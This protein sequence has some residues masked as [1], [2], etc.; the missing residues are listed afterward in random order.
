MNKYRR[1][2]VDYDY[3]ATLDDESLKYLDKFTNEYYHNDF[4]DAETDLHGQFN[5]IYKDPEEYTETYSKRKYVKKNNPNEKIDSY[6][7][8]K[9]ELYRENIA[10]QN[11]VLNLSNISNK[12][13]VIDN[14]LDTKVYD[15][16]FSKSELY[17]LAK[18]KG[19]VENYAQFLKA[20]KDNKIPTK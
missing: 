9:R 12:L 3:L 20:L 8:V 1:D 17:E 4:V 18:E 16:N 7:K 13:D 2:F 19:Y 5:E 10:K 15:G 6:T 14:E 11:C